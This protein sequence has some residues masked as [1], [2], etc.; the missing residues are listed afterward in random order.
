VCMCMCVCVYVYMCVC[1]CVCMSVYVCMCVCMCV[2]VCIC[3]YMCV[4]VYVCVYVCVCVCMCVC[5]Y[6]YIYVCVCVYVYVCVCVCGQVM[7]LIPDQPLGEHWTPISIGDHNRL[8]LCKLDF[9]TY[10]E[11]PHMYPMF[12]DL[13]TLSQCD[14]PGY[15][16]IYKIKDILSEIQYEQKMGTRNGRVVYPSGFVFH[17]SRVGSTLIANMFAADPDNMVFSEVSHFALLAFVMCDV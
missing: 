16:K 1:V 14:Q 11:Q 13:V 7:D 12:R 8:T 2:C 6:V 15:T 5:V 17:E 3:V 9:K 4:C 10:S